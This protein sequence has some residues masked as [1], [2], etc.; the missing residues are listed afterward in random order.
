MLYGNRNAVTD[1]TLASDGTRLHKNDFNQNELDALIREFQHDPSIGLAYGRE[2][3]RSIMNDIRLPLEKRASRAK[4]YTNAY[5][6]LITK[7]D[8]EAFPTDLTV[9]QGIPDYIPDGLVDMGA[10]SVLNPQFRDRD[11]IKI[12]KK[13]IFDMAKPLYHEVFMS[14]TLS[15][16][17]RFEWKKIVTEKVAQY[18]Y[19]QMPY[20]YDEVKHPDQLNRSIGL[21]EIV[22]HKLAVCRHHALMTQTLLQGFGITSRL[23]KSNVNYGNGRGGAHANNL[24]RIEGYWNLL[25]STSPERLPNGQELIFIRPIPQHRID[26]NA[27]TYEWSFPMASGNTRT[28]QSRTNMHWYRR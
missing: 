5:L 13:E 16:L 17:P 15:E 9:H 12:N 8:H 22:D 28:Y 23:I 1:Y 21:H 11:L 26:L 10:D 3:L 7:L 18:V 6:N 14:Q 27:L 25:D 24:V 19:Q 2:N 20:N 4:R